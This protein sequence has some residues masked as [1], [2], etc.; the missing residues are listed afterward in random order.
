MILNRTLYGLNVALLAGSPILS[1]VIS[2][3][4]LGEISPWKFI[5]V[6]VALSLPIPLLAARALGRQNYFEYW[7]YLESFKPRNN[8]F[9]PNSKA[10][11]TI[12]W[13][14]MTAITLVIG[15]GSSWAE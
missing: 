10:N 14:V 4:F 7:A 6:G 11:I 5:W 2:E 1:V 15:I 9:P 13:A 8:S 12:I 3:I